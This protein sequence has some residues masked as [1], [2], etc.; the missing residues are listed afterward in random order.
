[1]RSRCQLQSRAAVHC[2]RL[3]G[4]R[5]DVTRLTHWLNI[6]GSMRPRLATHDGKL[7]E[8]LGSYFPDG[9]VPAATVRV[10]VEPAMVMANTEA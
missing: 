8:D 2:R 7:K 5:A 3:N 9:S 6:P 1:M 4:H 10:T